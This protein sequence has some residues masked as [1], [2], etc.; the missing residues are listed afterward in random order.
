MGIISNSE[1][2]NSVKELIKLFGWNNFFS[3]I[4]IK[5]EIKSSLIKT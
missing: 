3:Y 5:P 1:N 4:E 2:T